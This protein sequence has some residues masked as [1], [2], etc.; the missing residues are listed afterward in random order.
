MDEEYDTIWFFICG[1]IF[2]IAFLYYSYIT[3]TYIHLIYFIHITT[4]HIHFSCVLLKLN[5][6]NPQ[7]ITAQQRYIMSIVGPIDIFSP[8]RQFSF[9]FCHQN[10]LNLAQKGGEGSTRAVRAV[11]G[12]STFL[13]LVLVFVVFV[14]V[15]AGRAALGALPADAVMSNPRVICGVVVVVDG[16]LGGVRFLLLFGSVISKWTYN[17]HL[18]MALPFPIFLT[19]KKDRN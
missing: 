19:C 11:T 3:S 13:L 17:R 1:A 7:Q 12:V 2:K 14:S 9:F 15:L 10:F 18:Y 5:L 4:N 8:H 16:F 6:K